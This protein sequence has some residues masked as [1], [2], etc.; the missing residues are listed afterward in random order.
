MFM[1]CNIL[2]IFVPRK[3]ALLEKQTTFNGGSA[4]ILITV[5]L[6]IIWGYSSP[7]IASPAPN[8]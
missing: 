3:M 1:K 5:T 2:M 7:N 8:V 6:G 4:I